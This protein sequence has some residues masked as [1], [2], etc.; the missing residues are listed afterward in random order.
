MSPLPKAVAMY[1][2]LYHR[3]PPSPLSPRPRTLP[4]PHNYRA[5]RPAPQRSRSRSPG[6]RPQLA[7]VICPDFHEFPE[8]MRE[9]GPS[10]RG[11]PVMARRAVTAQPSTKG[12]FLF[13]SPS[14]G[15]SPHALS[16]TRGS[17]LATA[18]S[19]PCSPKLARSLV[20]AQL[21]RE[22]SLPSSPRLPRIHVQDFGDNLG[23]S[24]VASMVVANV[25]WQVV[26]G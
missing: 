19:L 5:P 13:S 14:M 16:R 21:S 4:R 1:N 23:G 10:P 12:A 7:L 17:E 22:R 20:G 3:A 6:G 11:S 26:S 9:Y 15:R 18:S 2:P 25:F 8:G 24:E